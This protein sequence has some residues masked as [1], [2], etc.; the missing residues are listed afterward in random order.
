M[1]RRRQTTRGDGSSSTI[2][3]PRLAPLHHWHGGS[4][5]S[6]RSSVTTVSLMSPVTGRPCACSNLRRAECVS[7]FITPVMARS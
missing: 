4:E 6:E 1:D 7:G 5:D 2:A 3:S